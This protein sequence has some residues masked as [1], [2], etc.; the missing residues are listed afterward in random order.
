MSEMPRAGGSGNGENGGMGNRS[1]G[2]GGDDSD[3]RSGTRSGGGTMDVFGDVQL[4]AIVLVLLLLH[5][6]Q[7]AMRDP[8]TC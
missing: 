7:H 2:K 5:L 8:C 4:G 3:R 1:N 6:M